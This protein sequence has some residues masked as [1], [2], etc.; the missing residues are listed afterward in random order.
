MVED[1]DLDITGAETLSLVTDNAGDGFDHDANDWADARV[2][3]R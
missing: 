1:L 3:C 2:L